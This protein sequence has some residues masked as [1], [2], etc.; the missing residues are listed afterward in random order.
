MNES[1]F[2]L[3]P[4]AYDGE[5]MGVGTFKLSELS[6]KWL[7]ICEAILA[8][9]GEVFRVSLQEALSHLEIQLTSSNGIGLGTFY[10]H[11]HVALSTSYLRGDDFDAE[12]ELLQMFV[13]SLR[14]VNLVQNA[15]VNDLPFQQVFGMKE[16]PLYVVVA[17]A[18]PKISAE[19]QEL[20]R[21]L[22][23]HFAG[24]FLCRCAS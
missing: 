18:N 7:G 4:F 10:A 23:N 16:R 13:S 9:E 19:D 3:A 5:L 17:W 12:S 11:G 8:H 2:F 21:E 22:S 20:I 14:Q 15:R 1:T 24:A 6:P